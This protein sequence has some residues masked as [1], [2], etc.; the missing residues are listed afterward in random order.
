MFSYYIR[1]ATEAAVKKTY[2]LPSGLIARVKRILKAKTETEAIVTSL[3]RV[4]A[5]R[6]VER[7]IRFMGGKLPSY[8]PLR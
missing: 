2:N 4:A 8:R 5:M 1:M 3:E 6:K 7:V